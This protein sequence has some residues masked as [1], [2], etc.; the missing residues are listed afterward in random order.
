MAQPNPGDRADA[1]RLNNILP[2]FQ[3]FS[4]PEFG[5]LLSM[6]PKLDISKL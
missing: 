2:L 3:L 5:I 6:K 4:V 1:L